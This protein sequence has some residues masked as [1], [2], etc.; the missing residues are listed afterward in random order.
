MWEALK[1][2]VRRAAAES[3]T[4]S[5]FGKNLGLSR[6]YSVPYLECL[7]RM[8]ILRRQGDR[9]VVVRQ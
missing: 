1:N 4:A 3:F 2:R 7:N 6:K 8:G 5:E 9:H